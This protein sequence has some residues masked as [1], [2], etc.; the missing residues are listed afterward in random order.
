SEVER[1]LGSNNKIME[2]TSWKPEYNLDEG[3]KKTID[4]FSD[5]DNLNMYKTGIYNV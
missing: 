4:W 2:L 3:L 1:L 5:K